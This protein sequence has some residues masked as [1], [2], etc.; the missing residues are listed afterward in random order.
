MVAKST[1]KPLH[2]LYKDRQELL[3]AFSIRAVHIW[4]YQLSPCPLMS[5]FTLMLF[6]LQDMAKEKT[7]MC[8]LKFFNTLVIAFEFSSCPRTQDVI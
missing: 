2:S 8:S 7:N 6:K 5:S 3:L 1:L 4:K